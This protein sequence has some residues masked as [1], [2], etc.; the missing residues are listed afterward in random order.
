VAS[1]GTLRKVIDAIVYIQTASVKC[2]I[3][4]IAL[5]NKLNI[6]FMRHIP[7]LYQFIPS[8]IHQIITI[9]SGTKRF[10]T[11]SAAANHGLAQAET[12]RDYIMT[13][14][15]K[16]RNHLLKPKK[17]H[18]TVCRYDFTP[19]RPTETS[20]GSEK[21]KTSELALDSYLES[22]SK[23]MYQ[24]Y[25]KGTPSNLMSLAAPPLRLSL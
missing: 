2:M 1:Q 24:L 22:F 9:S 15:E 25:G 23:L 5:L 7:K 3:T 6:L 19:P 21:R 10:I 8:Q 20:H 11:T 13:K 4:Q 16:I 12:V 14:Q 18:R 17:V